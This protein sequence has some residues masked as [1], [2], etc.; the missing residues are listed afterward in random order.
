MSR[1]TLGLHFNERGEAEVYAVDGDDGPD[2]TTASFESLIMDWMDDQALDGELHPYLDDTVNMLALLNWAQREIV[3][4]LEAGDPYAADLR[5]PL[6]AMAS[7]LERLL[8][9]LS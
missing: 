1:F 4:H 3:S 8:E 7:L 5:A 9:A 6:D 2:D